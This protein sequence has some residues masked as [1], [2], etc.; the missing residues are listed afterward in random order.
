MPPAGLVGDLFA[1]KDPRGIILFGHGSGS[2]RL[3]PRNIAVADKLNADG[4]ATLLLDLLTAND[5]RNV[6]DIPLLAER[7]LE[8]SIWI[9][10]EPDIADLPLGPLGASTAAGAAMLPSAEF[11]NRVSAVVSRDGRPDLAG[12]RLADVEAPP[13]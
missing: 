2:S 13:C 12:P 1:P 9:G 10:A 3:S 8:A 4:F 6:F 7:L 11:R 5:R